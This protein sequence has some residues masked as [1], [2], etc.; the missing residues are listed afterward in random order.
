M[1]MFR[2]YVCILLLCLVA[3]C[4]MTH[5]ALKYL[6]ADDVTGDIYFDGVSTN[7]ANTSM[8]TTNVFLGLNF[9]NSNVVN[10]FS[11]V[12]GDLI[13]G[14]ALSRDSVS[15]ITIRSGT[16]INS[17]RDTLIESASDIS[18]TFADLDTG[19]E[20]ASTWYAV[21][22]AIT[23]GN[24]VGVLSTSM[25]GGPAGYQDYRRVG[26]IYNNSSS[27]IINFKQSGTGA[28]RTY[29]YRG[30]KNDFRVLN[31][32]SATSDTTINLAQIVPDVAKSTQVLVEFRVDNGA[33]N[34][35]GYLRT[36]TL[37]LAQEYGTGAKS[38][39]FDHATSELFF[40]DGQTKELLYRV[41]N[42]KN[43]MSIYILSYTEEL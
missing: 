36:S 6:M 12:A 13:Q 34:N 18:V 24:V 31:Q 22:V 4:G 21:Y 8:F 29:I 27:D 5:A 35:I 28:L 38:S 32:G 30:S 41:D 26:S 10:S 25:M 3:F 17:E 14:F 23:N 33:A 7:T 1:S 16:T 37:D 11:R 19:T 39:F 42:N 40:E 2:K 20:A 9:A 15:Q 43:D